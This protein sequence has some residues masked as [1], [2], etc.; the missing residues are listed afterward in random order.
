MSWVFTACESNQRS[1]KEIQ[2]SSPFLAKF[3]LDSVPAVSADYCQ[4]A[5][6][7]E[8]GMIRTHTGSQID[9]RM[10]AVHRTRCTIPPCNS[11]QSSQDF[12][13]TAMIKV[14]STAERTQ[15]LYEGHVARY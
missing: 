14:Y 1:M 2:N 4:R 8:S 10:T 3:S 15:T 13:V 11:N 7:D 5:L 6:V 9:H 12:V